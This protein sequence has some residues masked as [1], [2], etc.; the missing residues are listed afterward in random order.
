MPFLLHLLTHAPEPWIEEILAR[1]RELPE[2]RVEVMDLTRP[3]PDY[4]A[5]LEKIF[6]ADSVQVW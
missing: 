3:G 5:L 4:E 1:Q 2:S 6:Q